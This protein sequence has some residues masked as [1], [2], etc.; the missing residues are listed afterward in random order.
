MSV[1]SLTR[2]DLRRLILLF[3]LLTALITLVSSLYVVYRVQ[4]RELIDSALQSNRAYATKVASSIGEFLRNS[5][6]HLA[7]SADLLAG[8]LQN[9][10]FLK[11]EAIR[12]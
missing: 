5:H 9:E 4:K 12:L 1:R 10:G 11:S 8:Q 2:I 3:T 7:Y 6:E